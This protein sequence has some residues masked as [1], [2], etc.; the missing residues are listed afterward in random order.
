LTSKSIFACKDERERRAMKRPNLLQRALACLIAFAI[1]QVSL[2]AASP[3]IDL[4]TSFDFPEPG[5]DTRPSDINNDGTIVGRIDFPEGFNVQ[6][7]VRFRNGDYSVIIDPNGPGHFTEADAINNSG[8]IAGYY[9]TGPSLRGFFLSGDTYTDFTLPDA[10]ATKVTALNDAG[11]FAGQVYFRENGECSD[12]QSFVSIGGNVT[13]FTIPG[14]SATYAHGMNNLSQVVGSYSD[15]AAVHAFLRD[16]DGTLTF[17]IDYPGAVATSLSGI[18]D[19]GW[20][21]GY[22]D[23]TEGDFHALFLQSPTEFVVYDVGQSH[24]TFLSGINNRGFICGSYSDGSPLVAHGFL[25][26]VR[27]SSDN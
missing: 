22:Y 23:D 6:G 16:A 8:L 24:F 25:A 12:I 3:T 15:G 5:V 4:I 19:K 27:R 9:D 1:A 17:P 7:F 26:R 20:M 14:A 2:Q 21:T 18:N 13:Y 11:D 10:C